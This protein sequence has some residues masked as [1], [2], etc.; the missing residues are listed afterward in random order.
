MRA[1]RSAA[2]AVL[3]RVVQRFREARAALPVD[4]WRSWRTFV[5]IAAAAMF[6]LMLLVRIAA[7]R[8]LDG[9][10]HERERA[11]LLHLHADPPFPF[12]TAVFLQTFGSDTTLLILVAL[13][14]G[15][16]AW[17]RRPI[18]ALSI[19]LA[20]LVPDL[21]GRFGWAI[22]ARARPELLYDGIA[23]PGFHSFP[24]GHASKTLAVYGFLTV[25][26]IRAARSAGEK[27]AAAAVLAAIV[28]A[29]AIGR[30]AMGVHWPSDIIGG[31]IIGAAWLGVLSYGLRWERGAGESRAGENGASGEKGA[32]IDTRA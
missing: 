30:T 26:W 11:L 13:T 32:S 17:A 23:A 2:G 24:S 27:A 22:W 6:A 21:V 4:A 31:L 7:Q 9:G 16:A 5:T 29:V 18:T 20:G 10:L 14:T 25:V 12:S 8:I 15:I 1:P 28:A 3:K 19:P